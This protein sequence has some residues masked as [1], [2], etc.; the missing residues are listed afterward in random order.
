MHDAIVIYA[1]KELYQLEENVFEPLLS[2]VE[3]MLEIHEDNCEE[4]LRLAE[5]H[6]I[7]WLREAALILRSKE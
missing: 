5:K 6:N 4:A 2:A 7:D 1:H 3:K